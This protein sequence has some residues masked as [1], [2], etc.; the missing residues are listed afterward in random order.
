MQLRNALHK[1]HAKLGEYFFKVD[2][3]PYPTWATC[4][5]DGCLII[6]LYNYQTYP[7]V[8]D[9]RIN[10]SKL[11][12]AYQDEPTI[13]L[14]IETRKKELLEYYNTNYAGRAVPI[15]VESKGTSASSTNANRPA[16]FGHV[17]RFNKNRNEGTRNELEEYLQ[18]L[19]EEYWDCD[20][21]SWWGQRRVRFP[22]VSRLARDLLSIPGK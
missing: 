21:F 4:E 13:L 20:P 1:A 9:P 7:S 18:L 15:R 10:Y 17:S 19:P 16:L 2:K 11:V 12:E 5:F 22:N 14:E 3:S 8:L 6:I